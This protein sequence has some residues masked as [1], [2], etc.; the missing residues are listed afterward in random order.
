LFYNTKGRAVG[1]T[2]RGSE[3]TRTEF[4]PVQLHHL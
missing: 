4:D 3:S 2:G 1:S